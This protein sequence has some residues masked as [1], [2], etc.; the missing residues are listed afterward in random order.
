ME[1]E[2][3]AL[4]PPPEPLQDQVQGPVPDAAEAVP[5]EHR[6][7]VGAEERL[8]PLAEP[9]A[10]FTFTTTGRAWQLTVPPEFP[11]QVQVQG[12]VPDTVEG[13]PAEHK[14]AGTEAWAENWSG[15][16]ACPLAGPQ[17]PPLATKP[18]KQLVVFPPFGLE[19]V[20]IQADFFD[21]AEAVPTEHKLAVGVAGPPSNEPQAPSVILL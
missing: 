10:P 12:P 13:V 11:W 1:A 15:K 8:V 4:V 2:Q 16:N 5:A 18:A 19:Q 20:H 9:Q 17:T 21:T 7:A 14:L 6:L 3:L